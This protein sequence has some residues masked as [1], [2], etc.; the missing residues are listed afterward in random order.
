ML[1]ENEFL[2][3]YGI[4]S[5]VRLRAPCSLS[6][7]TSL[8]LSMLHKDKPWGMDVHGERHE[9]RYWPGDSHSGM[10]GGN[11]NWRG[12]ICE[13]QSHTRCKNS[14]STQ[15]LLSISCSSKVFKGFISIMGMTFRSNALPAAVNT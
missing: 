1:D 3:E 15:G 8:S 10:F 2:S 9:V 13:A 14:R 11:S 6:H 4:R 7:G 5:Y 12:P